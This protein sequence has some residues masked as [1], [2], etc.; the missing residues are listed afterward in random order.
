MKYKI[1]KYVVLVVCII[2]FTM[3]TVDDYLQYG[4]SWKVLVWPSLGLIN[5]PVIYNYLKDKER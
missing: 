5:T 1:I 4:L 2:A 3:L